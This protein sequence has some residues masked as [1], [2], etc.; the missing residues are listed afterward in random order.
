LHQPAYF[1]NAYLG[2]GEVGYPSETVSCLNGVSF[3][4][5]KTG[6]KAGEKIPLLNKYYSLKID[7]PK[8]VGGYFW[9]TFQQDIDCSGAGNGNCREFYNKTNN[10][11]KNI[12]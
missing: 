3:C 4:D 10:L 2:F 5:V 8:Y 7:V 12:Q 1:P 9:W 11:F 6:E